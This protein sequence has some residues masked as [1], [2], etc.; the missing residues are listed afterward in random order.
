MATAANRR[1]KLA[2]RLVALAIIVV[3]VANVVDLRTV[4]ALLVGIPTWVAALGFL[5]GLL[6]LVLVS[7]RWGILDSAGMME[8]AVRLAPRDYLRYQLVNASA[9]LFMPSVIG[10]DVARAVLV[11]AE[12]VTHRTRRVLVILFDRVLGILSVALLGTL[13]GLLAPELEHRGTYLS[14]V[15]GL[16]VVLLATVALGASRRLRERVRDR[17]GRGGRGGRWLALR[18]DEL[19]S[20]FEAFR[21]RPGQVL[22]AFGV[23][24]LVH[25]STFVLVILGARALEIS[26]PFTTL[27]L[28]TTIS[29]VIVLVPVSIGG[30]GLRELTFVALLAPQGVGDDQAAALSLFQF[31]V[32]VF[33]GL[34]GVP[35]VLL[36]R[37]PAVEREA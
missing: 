20:C 18:T 25:A 22:L 5:L 17:L 10:G 15:L 11:A 1:W 7:L 19:G 16:D 35:F 31:S 8:G 21:S 26:V 28:V 30:L 13:A 32:S 34:V 29:W 24:L 36:G 23:C 6:R 33:V 37:R 2:L 12:T 14:A 4:F 3:I 9:N 27:V